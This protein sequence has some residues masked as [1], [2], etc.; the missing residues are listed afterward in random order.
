MGLVIVGG[1]RGLAGAYNGN[2]LRRAESHRATVGREAA[3]F[4]VGRKA[5]GHFRYRGDPIQRAYA[6]L[7]DRPTYEDARRVAADVLAAFGA[8]DVDAVDVVTT[9]FLSVATQ[10]VTLFRLLPVEVVAAGGRGTRYELE[11]GEPTAILDRLLPRYVEA[12]L[13]SALLDAAA[14]EHAARQRA[15]TAATDNADELIKTLT[16]MSNRVRQT[17]ITT[18][19][20]EIVG[21]AQALRRCR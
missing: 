7:T 10:R 11:P 5:A 8:G 9:L 16:R 15:M 19:L 18:Q 17:E 20:V 4:V 3:L 6:G 21:G 13:F 12:R 14:S 1:D 2:V